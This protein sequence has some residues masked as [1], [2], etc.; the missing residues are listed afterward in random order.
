MAGLRF[1]MRTLYEASCFFQRSVFRVI[2]STVTYG[3][4]SSSEPYFL[5]DRGT[6]SSAFPSHSSSPS[7]LLSREIPDTDELYLWN[8]FISIRENVVYPTCGRI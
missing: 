5:S 7:K 4:V 1:C 8:V 2:F 3:P 6:Y